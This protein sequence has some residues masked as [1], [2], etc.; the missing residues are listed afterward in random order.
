MADKNSYVL[1][2][3][4][5]TKAVGNYIEGA[6]TGSGDIMKPGFH[7]G[8]TI[9]GYT[10]A[11]LFGGPIAGLFTWNDGNGA[12]PTIKARFTKID[13]A[14]TAANVRLDIDDWQGA[15][16]TDFFNLLKVDGVWKIVSKVY[17]H[18]A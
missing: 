5:I 11:N 14:G 1:D 16:F 7:E 12:A 8:A 3:D 15:R 10:G 17:H 18:H 2:A 9:Y 4:E 13:I 6:R